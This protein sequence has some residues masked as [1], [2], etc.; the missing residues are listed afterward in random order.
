MGAETIMVVRI[1]GISPMIQSLRSQIV[2]LDD[3]TFGAQQEQ[4]RAKHLTNSLL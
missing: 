1:L 2:I 4:A 3:G